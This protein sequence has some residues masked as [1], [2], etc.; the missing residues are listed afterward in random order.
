VTAAS[1]KE[2]TGNPMEPTTT[3]GPLITGAHRERVA[4]MVAASVATGAT[5]LT[6]GNRP[7]GPGFFY[8][9]TV[10]AD[11]PPDAPIATEEVFG[12]ILPVV[13]FDTAEEAIALANGVEHGLTSFVWTSDLR[14][15]HTVSEALD[16]GMVGI[17][18]WYP[19]TPE[20][21]FGGSKQS[22]LG[23]ESGTEGLL[24]YLEVKT[25]YFGGL[26]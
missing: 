7:D 11:L 12:P 18:D 4:A 24:E 1:E 8:R 22:G 15:A 10:M 17:N 5:V 19:V 9:P 6:G 25:R 13:G 20:A 23:R 16:F 2:V 26:A 21:P 14:T 3:V